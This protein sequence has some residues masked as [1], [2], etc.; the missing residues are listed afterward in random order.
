MSTRANESGEV[1]QPASR[2]LSYWHATDETPLVHGTV[3][4]LLRTAATTA[5]DRIA[6]IDGAPGSERSWTYREFLDL[7]EQCA[8][9]L[10]EAHDVGSRIGVWAANSP[11]WL[12]LQQA[13]ALAGMQL[14]TFNPAYTYAELAFVLRDSGC[15]VLYHGREHRG[16]DLAA[17]AEQCVRD[18]DTLGATTALDSWAAQST[19]HPHPSVVL[20]TPGETDVAILQYTSGTTGVPK[21]VLISHHAMVN[22]AN[23]VARRAGIEAGCVYVNPMPTFHIGSCG[24]VTL[25]AVSSVGTQVILPGFDAGRV[26]ELVEKHRATALL[27]VP[28][29]QIAM[30]EHPQLQSRDVSSLRVILTGGSIAS[31][32]LV[33]RVKQAFGC[34]FSITFGQTE[35]GG[36]ATQTDPNGPVWEQV[37]TIGRALPHTEVKIVDPLTGETVP[38]GERGEICSRGPT[39]MV[40]YLGRP[41]DRSL[42]DD[43]WLH[44]GDL[45]SMDND[46]YLRVV[47]RLKDMIIRGGE[48][49]SPREIEEIICTHPDVV[50]AAVVGAPDPVWGEQVA[51]FVRVREGSLV[52][53]TLLAD[54]CSAHLARHKVPKI[55]RL[56]DT[57]PLTASGKV[58]KF[59]LREAL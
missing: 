47:G 45:G 36:P 38:I 23:L 48:N 15:V 18:I 53:E 49:I 6:I 55:W 31:A 35:T 12:L 14:V 52:D 44:Y 24:T 10:V 25:G 33:R 32:D 16:V 19:E 1:T 58:Q 7:A 27:A 3:G 51:A 29:M 42:H 40:G 9:D 11:E 39:T 57:L 13:C 8:R 22:S 5:P 56:V 59:K 50:D 4:D 37:E 34:R 30:L 46:G 41:G 54:L 2:E 17:I 26:L 21:G 43:G 28:T 20:P